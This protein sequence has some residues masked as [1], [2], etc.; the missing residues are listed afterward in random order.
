[1][2]VGDGLADDVDGHVELVVVDARACEPVR[3]RGDLG[4]VQ[5]RPWY[6]NWTFR[7]I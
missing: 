4:Q 3:G 7:S 1:M 5:P 6:Y 2:C